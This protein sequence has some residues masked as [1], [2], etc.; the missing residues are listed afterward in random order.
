MAITH[1]MQDKWCDNLVLAFFGGWEQERKGQPFDNLSFVKIIQ[2]P[3]FQIRL[4]YE[5]RLEA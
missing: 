2:L 1:D 5:L 3:I 4:I